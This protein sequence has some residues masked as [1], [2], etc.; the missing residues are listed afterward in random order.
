MIGSSIPIID[1]APY[2]DST[3][4]TH[5]TAQAIR[6]A[7]KNVGFFYV[8][9][10]GVPEELVQSIFAN[11]AKFFKLS[12]EEKREIRMEMAE[13][14][15]RGYYEIGEER[16]NGKVDYQ[17][18]IYLGREQDESDPRVINKV[19]LHGRNLYPKQ[20]P[21]LKRDIQEWLQEMNRLGALLMEAFAES[22]GLKRTIFSESICKDHF[23]LMVLLHY[24]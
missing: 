11:S 2:R 12:R 14:A 7:C 24:P 13:R 10:H 15:W 3:A 1:L 16:T 19:P 6:Y 22:L 18:G 5:E 23:A 17:E 20:L 8:K 21:E 9:N 4:D